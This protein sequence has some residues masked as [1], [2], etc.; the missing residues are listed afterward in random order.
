M[1]QPPVPQWAGGCAKEGVR[2]QSAPCPGCRKHQQYDCKWYVPLADLVFPSPEES[3]HCPQVH[4]I[5]DHELEDMKMKISTIKSEMQK[6]VREACGICSW[7]GC[8]ALD[9]G[10]D[11][12]DKGPSER[13]SLLPVCRKP[14]R[15]RAAPSSASRRRCLRT[16]SGCSST[17]LPFPSASTTATG[18]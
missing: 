10:W 12:G 16:N 1:S 2:H 14:T 6:E 9:Q 5:P 17:L 8:F 18:R 7:G 4:V 13:S 3:E 15:G 11:S